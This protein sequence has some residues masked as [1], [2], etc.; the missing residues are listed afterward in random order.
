MIT[1]LVVSYGYL[2]VLIGTLLEG[3]TVLLAA[4]FAV[5]RGL[6]DGRLV[7]LIAILGATLGDQLAFLLGRWKGRALIARFPALARHEARVRN[8]LERY[9]APFILVVRFL[10]GL[11][12]AGPFILGNSALPLRRFAL[13]NFLGAGLWAALVMGAGYTFG[14]AMAALLADLK[15]LEGY[16]LLAILLAGLGLGL[17]RHHLQ[18]AKR[19]PPPDSPLA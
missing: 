13:L 17:I 16:F 9:H 12:I 4:G 11:R 7:F 8:L 19:N 1:S 2:G 14:L 6:L 10:Y 15:H 5:H 3:E 18:A